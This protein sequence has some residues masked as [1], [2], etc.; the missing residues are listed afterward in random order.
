MGLVYVKYSLLSLR[1]VQ[2]LGVDSFVIMMAYNRIK[3]A[4]VNTSKVSIMKYFR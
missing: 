2:C 4:L 3:K 1:G